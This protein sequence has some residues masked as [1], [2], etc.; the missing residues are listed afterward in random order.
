MKKIQDGQYLVR[1]TEAVKN[2]LDTMNWLW[3]LTGV[4]HLDRCITHFI[5]R[6]LSRSC[7]RLTH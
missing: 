7:K 1:L 4:M 5:F 6:A 2:I 3:C